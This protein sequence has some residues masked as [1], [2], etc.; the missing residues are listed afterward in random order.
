MSCGADEVRG[1][2][3]AQ[4]MSCGADEVRGGTAAQRMSRE[5]DERGDSCSEDE[6]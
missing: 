4:R 2:T 5:A 6:S 1:G 3:A